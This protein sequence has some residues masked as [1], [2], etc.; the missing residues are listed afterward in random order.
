MR[1][2]YPSDP[3]AESQSMCAFGRATEGRG[4]VGGQYYRLSNICPL[5]VQVPY[6]IVDV[7]AWLI[8]LLRQSQRPPPSNAVM[9]NRAYV[10][11]FFY[12]NHRRRL[13]YALQPKS[14]VNNLNCWGLKL[15]KEG[16]RS[17]S[18]KKV[19]FCHVRGGKG[20][21][22]RRDV[23]KTAS[24]ALNAQLCWKWSK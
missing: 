15:R 18:F 3:W 5:E 16:L 14:K 1:K 8:I 4:S 2:A 22:N 23:D 13:N 21:V 7:N 6:Y 10:A 9:K 19:S 12:F 17:C 20:P 11:G 24:V